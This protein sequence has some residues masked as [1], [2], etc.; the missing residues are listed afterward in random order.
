MRL[1]NDSHFY[2]I[3]LNC[4][5]HECTKSTNEGVGAKTAYF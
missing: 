2:V 4:R 5:M 3:I 1:A